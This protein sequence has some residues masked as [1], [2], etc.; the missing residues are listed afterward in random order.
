MSYRLY[1]R[2]AITIDTILYQFFVRKIIEYFANQKRINLVIPGL[3]M[4]IFFSLIISIF[5]ITSS[6]IFFSQCRIISLLSILIISS[7][8]KHYFDKGRIGKN[9]LTQA[10]MGIMFCIQL[11]MTLSIPNWPT[12]FNYFILELSI[13]CLTFQFLLSFARRQSKHLIYSSVLLYIIFSFSNQNFVSGLI[14]LVVFNYFGRLIAISFDIMAGRSQTRT[15]ILLHERNRNLRVKKVLDQEAQIKDK[16]ISIISHD[17]RGPLS[18]VKGLV[19]LFNANGITYLELREHFK[20]LSKLL[21]LT[22]NLLDNIRHWS[23]VQKNDQD[24]FLIK[25]VHLVTVVANLVRESQDIFKKPVDVQWDISQQVFVGYQLPYINVILKNIISNAFKFTTSGGAIVISSNRNEKFVEISVID[26]GI[27]M[28]GEDLANLF[29]W[30]V[31]IK[32][33]GTQSE[34][35]SGMGLLLAKEMIENLRGE[36][37]ISSKKNMGTVVNIYFPL[38]YFRFK[39]TYHFRAQTKENSPLQLQLVG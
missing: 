10:S 39:E 1:S 38:E 12:L 30:D 22:F 5:T 24:A 7:A 16:L 14:Y 18:S 20:Y 8:L 21:N 17:I 27:G 32:T 3:I 9:F 28:H 33:L 6:D 25:E 26:N 4:V 29:R 23:G 19:D 31:R 2:A 37:K 36:I 34:L 35:G 13:T 15:D 11:L